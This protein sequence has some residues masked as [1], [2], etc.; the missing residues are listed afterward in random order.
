MVYPNTLLVESETVSTHRLGFITL[1]LAFDLAF[2]RP[3]GRRR[4]KALADSWSRKAKSGISLCVLLIFAAKVSF[5]TFSWNTFASEVS[6]RMD[7][8]DAGISR[9]AACASEWFGVICD[10]NERFVIFCTD[11]LPED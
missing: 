9:A 7:L 5:W 6:F 1:F 10:E 3:T 11:V 2:D 4:R 8:I